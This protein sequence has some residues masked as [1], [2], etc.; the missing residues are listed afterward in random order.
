MH[1]CFVC[2]E[3][4][5]SQRG[6]GI[7]SY[8]KEVAHGL[9]VAGHQITVICASDDTCQESTYDDEGVYVIRLRGGGI[10]S[11]LKLRSLLYG[12]SFV[13]YIAFPVTVS[14]LC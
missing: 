1:I 13:L 11:F 14:A 12:R 3:Y 4:P 10:F 6:G 9:H 7:A 5:P 8:I 2:R